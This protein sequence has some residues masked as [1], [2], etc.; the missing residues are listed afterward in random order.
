M[1]ASSTPPPLAVR[2]KVA[3]AAETPG[4]QAGC[5]P[6]CGEGEL[7]ARILAGERA[8]FEELVLR[9]ER[10]VFFHLR[11]MLRSPED[12]EDLTQETFLLVFRKLASYQQDRPFRPWVLRIARHLA[13]SRLRRKR[14]QMVSLDEGTETAELPDPR[15]CGLPQRL[16]AQHALGRLAQAVEQL[17]AELATLFHLRYHDELRI[18]AIAEVLDKKPGNVAVTLHRLREKLRA[19]VFPETGKGDHP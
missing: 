3:H 1:S 19:L 10:A 17:P 8:L 9:H 5:F 12:A 14:P 11:R 16:D 18:E 13:L 4:P 15:A 6:A 2:G 7:A